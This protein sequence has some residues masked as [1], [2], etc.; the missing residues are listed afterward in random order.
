MRYRPNYTLSHKPTHAFTLIELLVVISIIA[1]L[2]SI[3]LPS[4]QKARGQAK[5]VVCQHN[6]KQ[7]GLLFNMYAE[8]NNGKFHSGDI[9]DWDNLWPNAMWD[10][11]SASKSL[12]F[13]CCPT[14][15]VPQTVAS[16]SGCYPGSVKI[17]WTIHNGDWGWNNPDFHGSYGINSYCC[18]PPPPVSVQFGLFPTKRNWRSPNVQGASQVPF[19]LDSSWFSVWM[20]DN[21]S[22]PDQS[23]GSGFCID[24]HDKHINGLFLDWSVQKIALKNLWQLKWHR[25]YQ[26]S[27][28]P[29]P[30]TVPGWMQ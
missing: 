19:F 4:L 17:A 7:W 16:G 6:L 1:L 18:N 2:V 26:R 11:I 12:D 30:E 8:D 14:A 15:K 25:Y 5:A 27:L 21:D 13:T 10:T 22:P 20:N 3:L 9:T 23:P 29:R 28:A 24:R